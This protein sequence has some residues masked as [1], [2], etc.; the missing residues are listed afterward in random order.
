MRNLISAI[1]FLTIL[2]LGK[3][4]IFDPKGIIRFFPVVGVILGLLLAVFD[5][6]AFRL[7]PRPVAA[8]LDV[9][10]LVAVTGAFHLDGLADTADGLYGHRSR[11]KAL[12][13]MKDSRIG[14]M[15]LVAVVC[16]L[17]IK[18]GGIAC[19]DVHRSL[20]LIIIPS[21]ARAGMIFGIR[22]LEYGRAEGG[23][24][25]SFFAGTPALQDFWG[26]IVPVVLSFFLG[27]KGLWLNVVFLILT[28]LI[29][30]YYKKR[31]GC[32][33]GDM[34]GAMNEIIESLLFLMVSAGAMS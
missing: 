24:G 21:Y 25:H 19:L 5:Q 15:G 30:S 14:V 12:E 1:Q 2:P 17:S 26:L 11:E 33:T 8:L 34:L 32:I 6:A 10:F 13:I 23:T 7:W 4:G 31:I 9:I 20:L 29:L 18:W 3:P 27:W 28:I 22:F 16:G